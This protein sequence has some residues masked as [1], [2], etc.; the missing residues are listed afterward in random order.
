MWCVSASELFINFL[1]VQNMCASLN[2]VI[3]FIEK[4]QMYWWSN[5]TAVQRTAVKRDSGSTYCGQKRQATFGNDDINNN[6]SEKKIKLR[7]LKS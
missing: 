2:L 6:S 4:A 3:S 7:F 5:V 1:K